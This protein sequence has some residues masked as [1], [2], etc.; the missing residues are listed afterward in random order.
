[1]TIPGTGGFTLCASRD[2]QQSRGLLRESATNTGDEGSGFMSLKIVEM[3]QQRAQIIAK[4]DALNKTVSKE[5]RELTI[6]ERERWE[7]WEREVRRLEGQIAR[8]Q[9]QEQRVAELAKSAH[10]TGGEQL[11]EHSSESYEIA[12]QSDFIS[13][14]QSFEKHLRSRGLIKQPEFEKLGFGQMIR[15]AVTG[16]RSEIERRALA[17]GTDSAGGY[18][19]P[20]ITLSRF[21]DKMRAATVTVRAG[22]QTVPL[23]SDR[24]VIARTATDPTAAWR[25][26]N[27]A[28][29]VDD[30][31]YEAAIFQPKSLA[32]IVKV[33]RELLED[34]INI[35]QML[36]ASFAGA[37][38][39]E[40]DRVALVGSGIAPEPLGISETPNVGS[41]TSVGTPADY[42]KFVDGLA[43][44]WGANEVNPTAFVMAPRT[45]GTLSKMPTGISGDKTP[46][47]PPPVV[48]AVPFMQTT[49]IPVNLGGGG[50]E[51]IVIV[52]NFARLMIGIRSSLRVEILRELYAGNHQYGFVA[53]LR[54]DVAVEHP[55]SFAVLSGVTTG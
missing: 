32:V 55:E 14:D 38:A 47:V 13:R 25:V 48:A 2:E 31:T 29:A 42:G 43:A 17:E 7:N 35:E 18:T 9:V 19:V 28:V 21:I 4:M 54:A 23:N 24:T 33:S 40:L 8:D 52:G 12:T 36:E 39:V 6:D 1:M 5:Q 51:S 11:L 30:S 20:D 3:Q 22:A 50:N 44:L 53:H 46:L 41:V 45:L 27:A 16:P 34:S 15:A 26:E 49:S 10:R 37:M